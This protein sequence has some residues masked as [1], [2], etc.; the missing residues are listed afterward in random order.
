MTSPAD[1]EDRNRR[2]SLYLHKVMRR[3]E[4]K[5]QKMNRFV[6]RAFLFSLVLFVWAVS[7]AWTVT[8]AS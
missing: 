4:L 7:L 6:E 1:Y 8:L 3:R 5:E 2:A